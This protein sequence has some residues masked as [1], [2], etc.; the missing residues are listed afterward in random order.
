MWRA[1]D[2]RVTGSPA[3]AWGLP[4][5]GPR[6]EAQQP[7]RPGLRARPLAVGPSPAPPGTR[8]SGEHVTHL[9]TPGALELSSKAL[10]EAQQRPG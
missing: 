4:R 9:H 5:L 3:R 10:P 8:P 2:R 7:L 6:A 1:S